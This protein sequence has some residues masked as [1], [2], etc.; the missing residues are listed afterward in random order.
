[1]LC[2]HRSA[3]YILQ[4]IWTVHWKHVYTAAEYE[5]TLLIY[6]VSCLLVESGAKLQWQYVDSHT[7]QKL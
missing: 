4:C 3:L 2:M 6:A 5:C 1:M 7:S